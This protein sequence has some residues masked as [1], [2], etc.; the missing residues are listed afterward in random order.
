VESFVEEHYEFQIGELSKEIQALEEAGESISPCS[1]TAAG[2]GAGAAGAT[3]A[4]GAA[5]AAAATA[6][7]AA[8]SE[9]NTKTTTRSAIDTRQHTEL[10]EGKRELQAMLRRCC[11]DEVH[12]QEEARARAA[13]GPLP[14]FDAVD[15]T[16][17]GLI[18]HGSAFAAGLAKRV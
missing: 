4:A 2:A 8:G 7:A 5:T 12:H 18:F 14:W 1:T 3:A 13:Q 10:L 17:R 9:L 16:W 6:A 11:E 15:T